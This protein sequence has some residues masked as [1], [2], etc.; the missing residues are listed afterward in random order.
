MNPGEEEAIWA[1]EEAYFTRLY[2]ANYEAMLALVHERFLGWP[3]G[4]AHP[5]DKEASARFMRQLAPA[6]TA[7]TIRI[8]REGL[9]R[10]GDVALTQYLLHVD[11]ATTGAVSAARATRITHT[12]VRENGAW[13][14]LGGMSSEQPTL[15]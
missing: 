15:P 4:V 7:C 9:S 12:W 1:L 6:P 5:L 14:L 8:D 3:Q 11:N 13:R 2:Q 10:A